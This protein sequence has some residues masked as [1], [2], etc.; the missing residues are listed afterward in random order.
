MG[1][2]TLARAAK[3]GGSPPAPSVFTIPWQKQQ[4]LLSR[5]PPPR[6]FL[7]FALVYAKSS[8]LRTGAKSLGV[9]SKD[10]DLFCRYNHWIPA[11][12]GD[13]SYLAKIAAIK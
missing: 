5:S 8:L 6:R 1:G 10:R 9:R 4:R 3:T 7:F 13:S 12:G 2:T 11:I